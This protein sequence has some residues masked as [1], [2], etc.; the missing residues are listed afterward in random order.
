M[1]ISFM[2]TCIK[3]LSVSPTNSTTRK[4]HDNCRGEDTTFDVLP[5]QKPSV[6][7]IESSP[8]RLIEMDFTELC[9]N[10]AS[11]CFSLGGLLIFKGG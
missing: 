4:G 1:P 11:G 5:Y 7:E 6:M 2:C 8:H 3:L 10:T 9:I